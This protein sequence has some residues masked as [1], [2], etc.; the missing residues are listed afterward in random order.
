M[1]SRTIWKHGIKP[2]GPIGLLLQSIHYMGAALNSKF[3]IVQ[4][5]EVPIHLFQT[6]YQYLADIVSQARMR[7]RTAEAKGTKSINQ[8][9]REIEVRATVADPTKFDEK[10]LGYL[11]TAQT[12][13]GG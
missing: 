4:Y 2:K 7:A 1:D 3:E 13:S 10:E 5:N 12:G 8:N 9:L 11:L 6:P